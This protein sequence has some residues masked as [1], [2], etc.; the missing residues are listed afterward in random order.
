MAR[1]QSARER[2]VAP[3]G[4]AGRVAQDQP[5]KKPQKSYHTILEQHVAQAQEELE[6]PAS[7]LL[8]SSFSAGLD[9]GF[10]PLL[11]AVLLTMSGGVWP[12]SL[13]AAVLAMAY[14][15]GFVFVVLGRSALFTEQTT[16]AVL[17][18]LAGRA[19]LVQLARL[20]I[21]VL[22]GNVVGGAL[23][24]LFLSTLGPHLH[25]VDAAAFG[26]IARKLLDVPWWTMWGSAVVA[27]WLMGLLAWL[28]AASRDTIAQIVFVALTTFL[29]GIAGFHHSIA[30]TIEILLA[31][32]A[33]AGPTWADYGRFIS[34][35]AVGNAIGG[36]LFV[37]ALKFGHVRASA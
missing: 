16:S 7:G 19:S 17:P 3:A 22:I 26:T 37:A 9:L 28:M 8:L 11:M 6:R 15:V 30:G 35:A 36:A 13:T 21:L 25:I 33:R 18:V 31:L 23:F 20:W 32:F 34:A 14:A 29:I 2:G 1:E 5:L 12:H 10:G 24:A 4:D 27:G